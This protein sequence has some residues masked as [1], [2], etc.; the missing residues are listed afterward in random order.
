MVQKIYVINILKEK[1]L[2][3]DGTSEIAAINEYPIYEFK[4]ILLKSSYK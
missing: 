4:I 2:K 1:Q 3:L